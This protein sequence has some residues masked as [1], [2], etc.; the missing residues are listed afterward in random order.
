MLQQMRWLPIGVHQLAQVRCAVINGDL[1]ERLGMYR[2][3]P[4]AK[5]IEVVVTSYPTDLQIAT[6]GFSTLP[7]W[8][9]Q[10][11]PA[12]YALFRKLH[13]HFALKASPNLRLLSFLTHTGKR[14]PSKTVP[15]PATH[16][17]KGSLATCQDRAAAG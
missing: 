6:S 15:E 1:N 13:Y 16:W 14:Q 10:L 12:I 3:P 8:S 7:S 17:V 11:W 2:E 9:A 4:Q 5:P